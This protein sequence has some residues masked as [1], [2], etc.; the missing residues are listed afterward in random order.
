[1]KIRRCRNAD[2]GD[3]LQR[4]IR[5][6]RNKDLARNLAKKVLKYVKTKNNRDD[7][8]L[9]DSRMIYDRVDF[10]EEISLSKKTP[11]DIDW[12][13]HAEYRSELRDV[14]P[15]EVNEEIAERLRTKLP[16]PD[17]KK[18]KFKAPGKGTM[19]VDY[20]LRRKPAE[21]DVVTVWASNNSKYVTWDDVADFLQEDDYVAGTVE[22]WYAKLGYGRD[23]TMGYDWLA[24]EEMLPDPKNLRKT[25]V[26]LGTTNVTKMNKIYSMMQ[27]HK[28][29][30]G[31]MARN[32]IK[33]KRLNHTSMSVGDLIKM[34]T[35]IYMVDKTGFRKL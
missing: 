20:D 23:A 27:G 16:K 31:G 19:V 22:I 11:L 8:S 18:V 9:K 5:N 28:W 3:V 29:S 14:D 32:L 17:S 33:K 4:I 1:M 24:K 35:T 13:D 6:I 7:L 30:P 34:G 21:A 25:H 12:T 10:G 2:V 15:R 26:L